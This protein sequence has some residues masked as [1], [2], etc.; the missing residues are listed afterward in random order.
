MFSDFVQSDGVVTQYLSDG[1]G[2]VAQF[3]LANVNSGV[4]KT[5]LFN[6]GD[7]MMLTG[8]FMPVGQVVQQNLNL[9]TA[10][11]CNKIWMVPD[12]TNGNVLTTTLATNAIQARFNQKVPCYSLL[13]H[14]DFFLSLAV[15]LI[16]LVFDGHV[17]VRLRCRGL[18][19]A[20]RWL[21]SSS[22]SMP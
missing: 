11:G 10:M 5:T 14:C 16:C 21:A 2:K 7:N 20:T 12:Q 13:F 6:I 9:A 1:A 3:N 8:A 18:R 4:F 19:A 22:V 17:F 15:A